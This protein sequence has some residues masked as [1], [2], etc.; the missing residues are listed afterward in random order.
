MSAPLFTALISPPAAVS[1]RISV[2]DALVLHVSTA[3]LPTVPPPPPSLLLYS[4]AV[5]AR[6]HAESLEADI[7]CA[8]QVGSAEA[9]AAHLRGVATRPLD[10]GCGA[11]GML[12][13]AVIPAA[14]V[15]IATG[16]TLALDLTAAAGGTAAPPRLPLPP[17]LLLAQL[18]FLLD[19]AILGLGCSVPVRIAGVALRLRV[20]RAT[21]TS[22]RLMRCAPTHTRLTLEGPPFSLSA[23]SGTAAPVSAPLSPWKQPLG[24]GPS[25]VAGS[26]LSP[27]KAA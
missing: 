5:G 16:L 4:A 10:A 24:S 3:G 27:W 19:G 21:P 20:T 22:A 15:P 12:A 2:G 8:V 9:L 17:A 18:P 25:A 13:L 6:R 23:S 1:W 11:P 26:P 7:A 14:L